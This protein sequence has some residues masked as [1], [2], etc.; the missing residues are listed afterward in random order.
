MRIVELGDYSMVIMKDSEDLPWM[1]IGNLYRDAEKFKMKIAVDKDQMT[2]N[3][4]STSEYIYSA[5][6]LV[7][8]FSDAI[9][10]RFHLYDRVEAYLV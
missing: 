10:D 1:S 4:L 8:F 3:Y 6:R 5:G 7:L 2:F 9:P